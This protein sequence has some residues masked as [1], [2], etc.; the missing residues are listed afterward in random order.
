MLD[1]YVSIA[2]NLF[3]YQEFWALFKLFQASLWVLIIVIIV[4]VA[5]HVLYMLGYQTP[6][7]KKRSPRARWSKKF[8]RASVAMSLLMLAILTGME[9]LE[10]NIPRSE[11]HMTIFKEL[12]PAIVN[13]G[14]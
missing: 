14:K 8:Y 7:Y 11:T 9:W 10:K 12:I 13:M 3:S 5:M 4:M 1:A 2:R 6:L